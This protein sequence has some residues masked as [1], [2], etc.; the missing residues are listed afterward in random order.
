[1][2]LDEVDLRIFEILQ[3]D[4]R[5]T[6]F[7]L[8]KRI[9]LTPAPTLARVKKLELSGY[10][11]RYVALV[12][13]AKLGMS[14]TAFVSVILESHKKKTTFD[15]VK[16]VEAM[17]EVLE[18]HHIA[19]DEDFLLKVVASSPAEYETFVLEKLTKVE[20]IEKVK[21]TFVLS[22]SKLETAIPVRGGLSS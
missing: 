17:P 5:I 21:T 7:D 18:C 14:V 20:G 12:D 4:G 6:N 16:A 8:A 3:T 1:M 10:I 15:F 13:Q 9:G 11:R 22:S 19:G 2:K